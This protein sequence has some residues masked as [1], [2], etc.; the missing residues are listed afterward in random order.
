MAIDVLDSWQVLLPAASKLFKELKDI[1]HSSLHFNLEID[2]NTRETAKKAIEKLSDIIKEQF[3]GFGKQPWF[4]CA[5]GT[6]FIRKD[7]ESNPFVK[8]IILPSC[9]H[10]GHK[11]KLDHKNDQWIVHDNNDYGQGSLSDEK[12][13]E[14][15]ENKT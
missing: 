1:R 3:A 9:C 6:T 7:W 14:L 13:I 8:E 10:V 2:T 4:I 12:F 5:K 11:H 15:F